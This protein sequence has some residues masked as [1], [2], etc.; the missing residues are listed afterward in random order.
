MTQRD[1][2][3]FW[4]H[5]NRKPRPVQVKALKWL[6]AQT[7][8]YLVMEAP[9]GSGKSYIGLTFSRFLSSTGRGDSFILTPQRI[10]QEQYQTEFAKDGVVPF[11]GKSNYTC[12]EKK[13]TCDVGGL[14]APKCKTCEFSIHKKAATAA[15]NTVLNYKLA[16]LS[17]SYTES[18]KPRAL[19]VLDECHS[20][21]DYLVDF[22]TVTISEHRAKRLNVLF[23]P[24]SE[25]SRAHSWL[26]GDYYKRLRER[27]FDLDRE[28]EDIM[29]KHFKDMSKSDMSKLRE[30]KSLGEHLDEVEFIVNSS[31]DDLIR[32]F[33]LVHSE[34]S[35]QFKP[36]YARDNFSILD[37]MADRFLFMSSTIFDKRGFCEDLGLP[38]DDTA[39]ISLDSEFPVENRPVYFSPVCKMNYGWNKPENQRNRDRMVAKIKDIL[40][41]FKGESGIIH[42]GNFAVSRWLV[43]E[44]GDKFGHHLI[45]DHNPAEGQRVDRDEQ[46]KAFLDC[47]KPSVLI[48]PSITEGLDLKDDKSRFCIF[49]KV[50]YPNLGDQWIKR[51]SEISDSWYKRKTFTNIVQG[52]GRVVRGPTDWG[53]V[54]ILDESFNFLYNTFQHRVPRWWRDGLNR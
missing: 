24:Q 11:Y 40:N 32:R 37:R 6:Q 2:L 41:D 14:C 18:F 25:M 4:P 51:R 52:A 23:Q 34:T 30:C 22:D 49:C 50:P 35:M 36:L 13:T 17:F 47:K 15:H 28:C 42:A 3:D 48:S 39:F 20:L 9:V 53:C 7:A 27:V 8:K 19:M 31:V 43:E 45:F 12:S 26:S 38:E 5:P 46:I 21:E 29:A 10:L 54:F 33:V 44:L 16:T 1:I